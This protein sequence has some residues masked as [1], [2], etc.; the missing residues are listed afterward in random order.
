MPNA[1]TPVAYSCRQGEAERRWT[2]ETSTD[3]L[4]TGESTG[5]AF[6]LVDECADR[7]MQVPLHRHEADVESFYV[8]EG[9]ITFFLGRD[10]P[11]VL[12]GP[13]GFVHIPAGA[14]H[15]FRIESETA[16]YLILTT[17]SHGSFYRDMT[18]PSLPDGSR[19]ADTATPGGL[20]QKY[21]IEFVGP[22]PS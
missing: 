2:S 12:N 19:P 11:G 3:F 1:T 14:V 10:A 5:G 8:L 13:G 22:L 18:V 7:G 20:G 16:R 6:A 9:G 21:G 4:A 17:P 15:G